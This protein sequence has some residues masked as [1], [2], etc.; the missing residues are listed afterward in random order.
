MMSISKLTLN[1]KNVNVFLSA[2][3]IDYD[4]Y[5]SERFNVEFGVLT[6]QTGSNIC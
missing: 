6:P 3:D 5:Q 2:I 4:I 1:R